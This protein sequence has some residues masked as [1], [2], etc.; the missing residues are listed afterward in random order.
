PLPSYPFERRRFW[1]DVHR[2][3]AEIAPALSMR[4]AVAG[5]RTQLEETV[6][7]VVRELLGLEEVGLHDDFFDLGGSSL[8]GLQMSARLRRALGVSVS[9]DLL[10]EAPTIAGM[11]KL[12]EG[13]LA[14]EA[15]PARPTCLVRLQPSGHRSP[16]FLVHQVGGYAYTFRALA[17]ELGNDRPVFGLRSLGLEEGEEPLLTIEAMAGHYLDLIREAQPRGPYLLGGASMG[18]M[19]AFEMAHQLHAAGEAV[20][21]L[22]LMDTPCLDQ[23]PAKEGHAEAVAAVFRGRVDLCPD[24]LRRL[25]P[26]EQ[27]A[28]AFEKAGGDGLDRA[29]IA[30]RVRVLH[31]NVEALYA[32]APRPNPGAMVYFRAESRRPGDPPRPELPWIEL[33]KGGTEVH[34]VPGDHMTMHEPPHVRLLAERLRRCLVRVGTPPPVPVSSLLP[35]PRRERGD[36][37]GAVSR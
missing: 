31:T 33:M 7:R 11:A 34:V 14:G 6:S 24:E 4:E 28:V 10:L 5:E 30:R 25:P 8:M 18:G 2:L 9:G 15:A 36:V 26:E 37:S 3:E 32:Y 29:E 1:V 23:M 13:R 19:V 12:L 17:R 20:A 27:L 21:L 22:A 16:L 35:T